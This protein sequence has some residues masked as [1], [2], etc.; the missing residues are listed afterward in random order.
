MKYSFKRPESDID[1]EML[2]EFSE[3][4]TASAVRLDRMFL[5]LF[6]V[7]W[8]A[9]IACAHVVSPQTWIGTSSSVHIHVWASI[10][11]GGLIAAGPAV[12][13]LS[14][15]G[16]TLSRHVIAAGQMLMSAL[17][18]H[19]TGGR[20]ETHF[21]IFGVLAF[22]SFYR[23]WR[24][25]VTAT[26]VIAADHFVRSN[27]WAESI[28][29]VAGASGWRWIEHAGW[30]GFEATVLVVMCQRSRSELLALTLQQHAD[31]QAAKS[32]TAL[33]E[34]LIHAL[35]KAALIAETDAKGRITYAN[36]TFCMVSGYS[37]EELIGTDHR[38]L[39]SGLHP[40]TFWTEMYRTVACGGI[41]RGEVRNRRKDGSHYWVDTT[42]T[43]FLDENGKLRKMVAVRADITD[44]KLAEQQLAQAQRLESIGQLAAGIAHEINT[45]T[46]YVGDNT[47]FLKDEMP[48]AFELVERVGKLLESD[49]PPEVRVEA[50]QQACDELDFEFLRE[51]VPQAIDQSLEG[52]SR[53]ATIV[54]AMKNFSH[55]GGASIER[56]D[57]N[58][59]I[60]STIEVCRNRWKY[61][62][63]LTTELDEQIP[64][65]PVLASEFNQVVLNL[66]VNAADAIGEMRET[67]GQSELGQI[68][69]T[70][71][72]NK[73]HAIIR[74]ID[75]GPGMPSHV[76]DRVFDPFFT[77]KAVGKGTGQGL[78]LSRSIIVN[79]HGGELNVDSKAG[80]G[81][82]FT[83]RLPL[84]MAEKPAA[85]GRRIEVDDIP[86]QIT[87]SEAA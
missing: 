46:Q 51:E 77:T 19:M 73:T 59:L 63:E 44:R 37:K 82:C 28:F 16:T 79:R 33:H 13:V 58:A 10:F 3:H 66:I 49:Q 56:T 85:D 80:S 1:P 78:A 36:D 31:R 6:A 72:A 25:I 30:V 21:H 4:L 47:Q 54:A 55:P 2:A 15:P 22:L 87:T 81:A 75:N 34:D 39:N 27:F 86:T 43:G 14:T 69:V 64:D 32:A 53:I 52:V 70:T 40:R 23:D 74:V 62:S 12:V 9:A 57:I 67:S 76:R 68:R 71:T 35:D 65:V 18:I 5:A 7:Q 41:W 38:L 17:L 84:T 60:R 50:F 45:P 48:R 24:V 42:I 20:I 8:M 83:I 29:G 26:V 11:L 61:V